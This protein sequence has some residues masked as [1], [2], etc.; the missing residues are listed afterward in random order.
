[1]YAMAGEGIYGNHLE[2]VI[3]CTLCSLQFVS[4]FIYTPTEPTNSISIPSFGDIKKGLSAMEEGSIFLHI[5][6]EI[7]DFLSIRDNG[8]YENMLI[9]LPT[10]S[11]DN[12]LMFWSQWTRNA[13]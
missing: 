2:K 1:M 8:D 11:T 10:S 6:H 13:I 9:Q 5:L 4:N 3:G 7:Y 12:Y